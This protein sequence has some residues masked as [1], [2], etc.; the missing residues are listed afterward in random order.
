MEKKKVLITRI[1]PGIGTGL[2]IKAGFELTQWEQDRP[3][4]R[5]ELLEK[6]KAHHILLATG[7]E[8]IDREFLS[9]CPNL[10]MISLFSMGYNNVDI[11]EAT[12]L[13]IPVGH[14]PDV[15]TEAT[16]DIAFVLMQA[17]A[18]K[19]FY[20]HKTILEGKWDY[21][22]PTSHLGMQLE[23]KTLGIFGLGRIGK[24]MAQRCKGAF[25]MKVI[26]H[27][28]KPDAEA[29]KN[30]DAHYVSF[31]ELLKQSDV[32][33]VHCPLTG[34]TKGIFNRQAFEQMK[35]TSIFINTARGQVHNETDLIRALET[36]R[37]R[38]A[39][40]DVTDPE[41]MQPDNPLLFMENVAVV[42]HIG[43]ATIEARNGMARLASENIIEFYRNRRIP[44]LVNPEALKDR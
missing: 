20:M 21:F 15:L 31:E 18:R 16:A 37:I 35:P 8:R 36:G 43:S 24:A 33:S 19:L 13:G 32:L 10:E 12:L 6:T 4:T 41:P 42:P 34:E 29:E 14:T 11:T 26:Y 40:L 28:R 7:T 1:I 30:L 9:E 39:G 44:H 25:N 5:T 27:N 3:M 23:N 22:R 2:L 17:S 38:G